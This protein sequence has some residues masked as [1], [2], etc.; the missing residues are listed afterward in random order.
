MFIYVVNDSMDAAL[1][2]LLFDIINK[3]CV[4]WYICIVGYLQFT[5][6]L[7]IAS[8]FSF[9]ILHFFYV[10]CACIVS[11]GLISWQ[12]FIQNVTLSKRH[13][14][15]L[16][17]SRQSALVF[18]E[19]TLMQRSTLTHPNIQRSLLFVFNENRNTISIL[20]CRRNFQLL[21]SLENY[22]DFLLLLFIL[23]TPELV[24]ACVS[25]NFYFC[26]VEVEHM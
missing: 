2:I 13:V 10:S 9:C 12:V 21:V 1:K 20:F 22:V 14:I 5:S 15:A 4:K 24:A 25:Y 16:R 7:A 11:S 18:L 23:L 17:Y 6:P 3:S 19:D 8:P 26:C